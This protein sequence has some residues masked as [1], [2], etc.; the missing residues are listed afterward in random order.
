MPI[1]RRCPCGVPCGARFFRRSFRRRR[2]Q[3]ALEGEAF[4]LGGRLF[5]E[6]ADALTARWAAY[7]DLWRADA[8]A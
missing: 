1:Q 8:A 6:S 4:A 3:K 2:W 7:W 5:T